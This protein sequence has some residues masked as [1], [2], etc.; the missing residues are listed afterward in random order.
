MPPQSRADTPLTLPSLVRSSQVQAETSPSHFLFPLDV[1][2]AAQWDSAPGYELA[3]PKLKLDLALGDGGIALS[4]RRAQVRAAA[5]HA[6]PVPPA[7]VL[8]FHTARAATP[9][10]SSSRSFSS[11]STQLG[12]SAVTRSARACALQRRRRMQRAAERGGATPAAPSC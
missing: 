6:R 7:S 4:L 3:W 10:R 9:L 5:T 8:V 12:W 11:A 1:T 2:V